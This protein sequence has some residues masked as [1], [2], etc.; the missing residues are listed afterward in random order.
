MLRRMVAP[1]A[2]LRYT[3]PEAMIDPFWDYR[4]SSVTAHSTRFISVRCMLT[5]RNN[6]ERSSSYTSSIVFEKDMSKLMNIS[7]P[8]KLGEDPQS[9]PGLSPVAGRPPKE[10]HPVPQLTKVKSQPKVVNAKG[11]LP[12]YLQV[13]HIIDLFDHSATTETG[14]RT[15]PDGFTANQRIPCRLSCQERCWQGK[16]NALEYDR[17]LHRGYS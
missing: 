14:L 5:D 1:N 9:P 10:R 12:S 7:P 8:W 17:Q 3:A 6:L 2:D 4:K 13:R 11:T 16:C 15:P